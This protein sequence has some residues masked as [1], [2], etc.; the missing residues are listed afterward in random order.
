MSDDNSIPIVVPTAVDSPSYNGETEK[1]TSPSDRS[2]LKQS[3][4]KQVRDFKIEIRHAWKNKDIKKLWNYAVH[5]IGFVGYAIVSVVLAFFLW[6]AAF[7]LTIGKKDKQ[8]DDSSYMAMV[9]FV[10][11]ILEV[12]FMTF[13][14]IFA[15]IMGW[16]A[17]NTKPSQVPWRILG[18]I[19]QKVTP[20]M[21]TQFFGY[22]TIGIV[23]FQTLQ[24]I[25]S[26]V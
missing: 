11:K 12:I 10:F 3:I 21:T 25:L 14:Q 18:S 24:L 8:G 6:F 7:F 19:S 26:S 2:N 23:G 15:G 4:Q 5:C 17:Y 9:G 20:S 13:F 22:G 1:T 16:G